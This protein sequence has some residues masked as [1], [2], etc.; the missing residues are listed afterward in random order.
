MTLKVISDNYTFSIDDEQSIYIDQNVEHSIQFIGSVN[1][2]NILLNSMFFTKLQN[3]SVLEVFSTSKNSDESL[4]DFLVNSPFVPILKSQFSSLFQ[5]EQV[6]IICALFN[7]SDVNSVHVKYPECF[8]SG[9]NLHALFLGLSQ[10]NIKLIW[11]GT[12]FP[13]HCDFDF[14]G[15]IQG[16]RHDH[17]LPKSPANAQNYFGE[18]TYF[19]HGSFTST[20][21]NFLCKFGKLEFEL[22]NDDKLLFLGLMNHNIL[23]SFIPSQFSFHPKE[24]KGTIKCEFIRQYKRA[25]I[26]Y[27]HISFKG[28]PLLVKSSKKFATPFIFVNPNLSE[29]LIFHKEKDQL[30]FP[31]EA[32]NV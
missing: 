23:F 1:N 26:H 5:T 13:N 11:E 12:L 32:T 3:L 4:K 30:L 7:L 24:K 15:D 6:Q 2:K 29:S 19:L 10:L 21:D 16:V 14:Y 17:S 18:E 31:S 22:S 9:S 27:A 20:E 25:K 8:L 28:I